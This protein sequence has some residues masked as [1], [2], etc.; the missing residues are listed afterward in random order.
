[1]FKTR[2][3]PAALLAAIVSMSA[4]A[5]AQDATA[6]APAHKEH[7]K[8]WPHHD[9]LPEAKRKLLHDAM[10]KAHKENAPLFE[11][12]HTLQA[13]LDALMVA[14]QFDSDAY[15]KKEA[16]I[17]ELQQKMHANSEQ[18][19]ASVLGQFTQE[20]RVQLVVMHH[21]MKHHM[22]HGMH[23]EHDHEDWK[24]E[25]K[26]DHAKQSSAERAE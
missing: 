11:Q 5:Y 14:A 8:E 9:G 1:M 21:R 23:D 24:H 4:M 18:A 7:N 12:K 19:F 2:L 3:L 25:G 17:D 6:P 15:A 26:M 10:E 22:H 16:Q 13:E 20:E